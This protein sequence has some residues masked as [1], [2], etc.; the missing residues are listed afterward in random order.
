MM[1]LSGSKSTGIFLIMMVLSIRLERQCNTAF[2]L[3]GEFAA[4]NSLKSFAGK[5]E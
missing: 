1:A 5:P 4:T 3:C 2:A